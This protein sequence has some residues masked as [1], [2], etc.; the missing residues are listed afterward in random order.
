MT[1]LKYGVENEIYK[2]VWQCMFKGRFYGN[3]QKDGKFIVS[4]SVD[5]ENEKTL[6]FLRFLMQNFGLIDVTENCNCWKYN[7]ATPSFFV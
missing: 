5:V 1:H 6:P 2:L 3:H 4:C 7:A